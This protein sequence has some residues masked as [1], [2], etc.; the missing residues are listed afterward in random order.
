M[1][2]TIIDAVLTPDE[3]YIVNNR[4]IQSNRPANFINLL[5]YC[6]DIIVDMRYSTCNNFTSRIVDGYNTNNVL[7]FTMEG[8]IQLK[9]CIEYLRVNYNY[10]VKIFDT[11]RPHRS[12]QYFVKWSRGLLSPSTSSSCCCKNKAIIDGD[13]N[14]NNDDHNGN[15][16]HDQHDSNGNHDNDENEKKAKDIYYPNIDKKELLFDYGYIDY[17]SGHSVVQQLTLH[18]LIWTV[19]M[20][21]IWVQ[22]LIILVVNHI[23]LSPMMSYYYFCL[24]M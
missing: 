3:Q 12:V 22:H 7:Y 24:Q 13:N 16:H 20:R 10:G 23:I 8:A 18:L 21:L 4:I 9:Q 6:P 19:V 11:Y 1:N 17:F 15:N 5:T 2:Q 14:N